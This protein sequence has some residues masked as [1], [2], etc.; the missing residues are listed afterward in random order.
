MRGDKQKSVTLIVFVM[1]TY[2]VPIPAIRFFQAHRA[3]FFGDSNRPDILAL[4][5]A[6]E[7]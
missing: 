4:I 5:D 7:M 3:P 1:R 2:P 6:L